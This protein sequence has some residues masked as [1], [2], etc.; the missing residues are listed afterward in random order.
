MSSFL[1]SLGLTRDSAIWFWSKLIN[2][3]ILT[4]SGIIPLNQYV[5]DKGAHIVTIV[6]AVLLWFSGHYDSSSLP[7]KKQ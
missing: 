2:G 6:C 5:G 1:I 3:A 7:G 4:M